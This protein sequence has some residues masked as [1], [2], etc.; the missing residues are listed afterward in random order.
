M[1]TPLSRHVSSL[2]SELK[3]SPL[4]RAT[5]MTNRK[6]T[7]WKDPEMITALSAM[8]IGLVAVVI[9]AYQAK[10]ASDQRAASVW[11]YIQVGRYSIQDEKYG[12]NIINKG[13]G[14]AIIKQMDVFVDDKPYPDWT[15]VFQ[16]L[17]KTKSSVPSIYSSTNKSVIAV[18]ETINMIDVNSPE[19]ISKIQAKPDNIMIQVCYCSIFEECW[20]TGRGIENQ[21]VASCKSVLPDKFKQ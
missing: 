6:R 10:V 12:F 11:P 2:R 5:K 1:L 7:W 19:L 3:V 9:G 17:L 15:S 13:V 14:P 8:V 21:E 16:A 4:D 18:N 20:L